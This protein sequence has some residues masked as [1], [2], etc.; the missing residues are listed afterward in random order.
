M[1]VHPLNIKQIIIKKK[2]M[3][4]LYFDGPFNTVAPTFQLTLIN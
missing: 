2:K 4:S 3:V 1:P